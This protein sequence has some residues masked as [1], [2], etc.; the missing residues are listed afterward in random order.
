MRDHFIQ[1]GKR[2]TT[3][4]Q[5]LGRINLQELLLRMFTA[6]LRWNGCNRTFDQLQQRLLHALTRYV[7][8]DGRVVRFT[9]DLVDL[10]DV[11]NPALRFLYIVIAFLQQFLDDVFYVLTHITGFG[12]GGGIGHCERNIQQTRQ[13]FSQQRFTGA[14]WADQQNI[15]FTQFYAI[16]GITVTQAFV[17]VVYRHGEH[18]FRLLLTDDIVVKM[19]TNFM[20]RWQRAALAVRCYFFNLFANNVVT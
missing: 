7:T 6:T 3:D 9:G 17:V 18:F 16:A 4:E 15:T 1:T 14:G 10:I 12:Q 8:G 5:D 20:R 2:T 19:M 11:N 13:R